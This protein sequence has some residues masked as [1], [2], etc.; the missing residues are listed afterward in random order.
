MSLLAGQARDARFMLEGYAVN[1]TPQLPLFCYPFTPCSSIS[2]YLIITISQTLAKA[3]MTWN[4]QWL[5]V[6][7]DPHMHF[8][9]ANLFQH[10]GPQAFRTLRGQGRL[11]PRFG[12]HRRL[13]QSRCAGTKITATASTGARR[14]LSKADACWCV[15]HLLTA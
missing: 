8:F 14:E 3:A 7:G 13:L 12:G 11:S 15:F 2:R 10:L 4:D 6:G 9:F 1:T 5:L